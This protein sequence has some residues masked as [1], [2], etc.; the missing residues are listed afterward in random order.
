MN[1][2]HK[3]LML[4]AFLVA[5]MSAAA[6][7][8][9]AE[10]SAEYRCYSQA[11]IGFDSVINSRLGVLPEHVLKLALLDH[12]KL[13]SSQLIYSRPMLKTILDA[14]LWKDSPHNYAVKVFYHCAQQEGSLKSVQ[15]DW[16]TV[17]H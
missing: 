6:V 9:I 10:N 1:S 14:Y 4:F 17:D 8:T 7:E 13:T 11:M 3:K 16:L 15:N 12:D 5:P 2:L